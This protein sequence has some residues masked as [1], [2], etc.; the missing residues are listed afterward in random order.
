MRGGSRVIPKLATTFDEF[1]FLET[2][3]FMKTEHRQRAVV[4]PTGKIKWHRN[5]T[6]KN[7][8]IDALLN[9]NWKVVGAFYADLLAKPTQAN[10]AA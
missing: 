3:V 6:K 10:R 9:E 1:T 8:P 7:E 5:P 2:T 4:L